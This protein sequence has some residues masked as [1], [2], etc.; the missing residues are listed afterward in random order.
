MKVNIQSASPYYDYQFSVNDI[1]IVG[2]FGISGSG[3]SSLLRALAG[4]QEKVVGDIQLQS[5]CLYDSQIKST[6][7]VNKCSYMSQDVVLFP[8]WT[9][10]ENLDFAESHTIKNKQATQELIETLECQKLVKKYPH[11]LSGGET[12]RIAFIRSLICCRTYPLMLLDEPFSA[13]DERM[14]NIA[15]N[16]L[17]YYKQK[18][19]IFF[20]THDI[21]ELYHLADEILSINNGIIQYQNIIS[22]AMS[23]G[24]FQLPIA[25]KIKIANKRHI[26]Y[27]DDVSISLS[28]IKDSSIIHQVPVTIESIRNDNDISNLKLKT[29]DEQILFASIT[30]H[31]LMK[32]K[33]TQNQAVMANFKATAFK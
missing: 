29:G 14:R 21:N 5:Q 19:L 18:N 32:L 20:V 13:L 28:P 16:L 17:N 23:C 9:V 12:Q 11:Q 22:Q 27:A 3:K 8:H 1:G 4:F 26:I 31:S 25:S 7:G 2:V 30:K 24:A 6:R 10:T 15:L 33:L